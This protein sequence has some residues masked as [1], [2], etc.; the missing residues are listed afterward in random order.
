[1]IYAGSVV[2]LLESINHELMLFA[3][4][5]FVLGACDDLIIDIV[6]VG[7]FFYR[8]LFIY[9]RHEKITPAA[10][11]P[12]DSST[13]IAVFVPAW[14]ESNVIGPMLHNCLRSWG[15]GEYRI[16]VG[17]YPNDVATIRAI[18]QVATN[19]SRI[20]PVI[21]IRPGPTTK[22][23]CLNGIWAAMLRQERV[24][25]RP[26]SAVLLHDAED[27][28]HPDEIRL[29]SHLVGRFDLV[30]I[31]VLP[32]INQHS[33]WISGHYCDEFAEAH[34][35]CLT[36]REAV[37]AAMPAAGVGCAFSR[38]M[39]GR[40]AESQNGA[41]FDPACLT[42]DYE[43][44]LRIGD[45][46]GRG[47]FVH[48]PDG[49]GG[50]VCTREYFPDRLEAA[51]KQKARW[52]MGIAL[53]G[54]DRLGWRGHATERWMRLRDRRAPLA[55]LVLCC[56]YASMLLYAVCDLAHI[57]TGTPAEPFPQML[58]LLL[59]LNAVLLAWRLCVRCF[60]VTRYYGWREGLRS[61][62][63]VMLANIIAIMAARRAIAHY[64]RIIRGAAPVW[65]KTSH[66]FPQELVQQA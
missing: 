21:A 4:A 25:G 60:F 2:S 61:M 52:M 30:Q 20:I 9:T 38:T 33:R 12:L 6:Y 57:L 41:P 51:V 35:K 23:D 65:E 31:P 5:G 24:E 28:V 7:R 13:T 19:D 49:R 64:I 10:L 66:H 26:F 15:E 14:D 18:E 55:A 17:C 54:W 46:G 63:R 42:E 53:A 47:I 22:G 58:K 8:R 34:G 45:Q 48:M 16:F 50:I 56:A 1:M 32:L 62:P 27:V 40:I 43:L 59:T 3:A 29:F 39:I 44:G 36:V 37:G 11:P